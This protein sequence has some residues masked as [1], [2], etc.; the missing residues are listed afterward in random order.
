MKLLTVNIQYCYFFVYYYAIIL[1]H[2]IISYSGFIT[3]SENMTLENLIQQYFQ[4]FI[5]AL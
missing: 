5:L 1:Y 4:K 3:Y 2:Y